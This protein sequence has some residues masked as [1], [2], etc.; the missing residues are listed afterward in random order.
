MN[1]IYWLFRSDCFSITLELFFL[2]SSS[3]LSLNVPQNVIPLCLSP[4]WVR[5]RSSP[6]PVGLACAA[7]VTEV[8][9]DPVVSVV[10]WQMDSRSCKQWTQPPLLFLCCSLHSHFRLKKTKQKQ[11]ISWDW[12]RRTVRQ[13]HSLSRDLRRLLLSA[14]C[15]NVQTIKNMVRARCGTPGA[16]QDR[17]LD[18]TQKI[19]RVVCDETRAV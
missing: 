19:K 11:N 3:G 13:K 1:E 5:S 8:R 4:G 10:D 17:R 12:R 6:V 9:V 15:K 14:V 16:A 18:F 7:V 2:C